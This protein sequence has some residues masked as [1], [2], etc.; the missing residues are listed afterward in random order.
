MP[1][2]FADNDISISWQGKNRPVLKDGCAELNS[3][4]RGQEF[5][6][7]TSTAELRQKLADWV[8]SLIS[9]E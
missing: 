2:F 7:T 3:V 8:D 5:V 4:C 1:A 6:I 9:R